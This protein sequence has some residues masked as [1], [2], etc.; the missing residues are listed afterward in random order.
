[1]RPLTP[2]RWL[3]AALVLALLAGIA[4][5]AGAV[6]K[7]QDMAQTLSV[8]CSELTMV[9]RETKQRT[10]RFHDLNRRYNLQ[11]I[12]TMDKSHRIELM[13]YSQ[14]SGFT[15]DQAYACNQAIELY[16]ELSKNMLPF[17][18]FE[19]R[20]DDQIEQ[21]NHL[22]H[23]LEHITPF[24]LNTKQMQAD[25]DSCLT[26]AR[27]IA[28]DM[29]TQQ[30]QLQETRYKSELVMAKAKE[31]NDYA[32]KLYESIRDGIFI[33]GEQS[34]WTT[35]TQW[36]RVWNQGRVDLDEK[37]RSDRNTRS[38]WRGAIV[39]F[40][41]AFIAFY[42]VMATLLSTVVIRFLI[43][44]RWVTATFKKKRACMI[45]AFSALVFAV[46]L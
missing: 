12:Q 31:L 20:Y 28:A 41:F 16:N 5:N 21:Y 25:R 10:Q 19:K 42:A 2:T 13:L 18:R 37:Y 35:L 14:K 43:P 8:L 38:E 4:P 9:H 1:M 23:S 33:N 3:T 30:K 7:E 26:L 11:M 44:S 46:A 45:V 24:V 6:L 40:L 32:L 15:F 29:E 36:P 22:A 27:E 17:E 39:A 34:Y